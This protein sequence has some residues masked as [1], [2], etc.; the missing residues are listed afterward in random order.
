MEIR[1][2]RIY[3]IIHLSAVIALFAS[4]FIF[5]NV[6][7]DDTQNEWKI[8]IPNGASEKENFQGFYPNDLPVNIGDTIM[9]ENKDGA[10]HSIT[11]GLP[12]YPDQSGTFFDLGEIKPESS[13]SFVLTNTDFVAFYYFCEIHPWMTGKIFIGDLENAQPETETPILLVVM[14]F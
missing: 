5:F 3:I 14:V 13:R 1:F 12:K 6:Y 11:S 2:S 9:W 10:I 7:A 8:T 4:P